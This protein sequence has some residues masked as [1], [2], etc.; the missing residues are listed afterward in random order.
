[1]LTASCLESR[2][3]PLAVALLA[4]VAP[5]SGASQF[6]PRAA[7]AT[8]GKYCVWLWPDPLAG[9]ARRLWIRKAL[10][11][12]NGPV[13]LKRG[14]GGEQLQVIPL[15]F[16]VLNPGAGAQPWQIDALPS[17]DRS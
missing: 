2:D 8:G 3:T 16:R 10:V 1:M 15:R 17:L 12:P 7:L 9:L 4:D 5:V 14:R 13:R 11:L 6:T